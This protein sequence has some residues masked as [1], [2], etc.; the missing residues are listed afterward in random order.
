MQRGGSRESLGLIEA[1]SSIDEDEQGFK[2]V[3]YMDGTKM[4]FLRKERT[5]PYPHVALL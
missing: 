4:I 5:F 1:A 2:V 3:A